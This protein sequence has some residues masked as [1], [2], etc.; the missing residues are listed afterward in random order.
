MY[1]G[2]TT[3]GLA[4]MGGTIGV[5]VIG[6]MLVAVECTDDLLALEENCDSNGMENVVAVAA[7]GL[8]GWS[9][10]DAGRAARRTNAKHGLKGALVLEPA[11]APTSATRD[12]RVVRV[13]LSFAT[14]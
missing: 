13:G 8:Y 3:T 11:R 2:E 10:Y 7:L 12:G 6:S 1:A 4:Y 5:L 14:R 9:I